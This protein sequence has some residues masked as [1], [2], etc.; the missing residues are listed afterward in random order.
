MWKKLSIKKKLLSMLVAWFIF[1]ILGIVFIDYWWLA[2]IAMFFLIGTIIYAV[3]YIN[4]NSKKAWLGIVI[5]LFLV[6]SIGYGVASQDL[7]FIENEA[8]VYKEFEKSCMN[9]CDSLDLPYY[10]TDFDFVENKVFCS[11][12]DDGMELQEEFYLI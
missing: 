1:L 9:E 12:Y 2:L 10:D 6:Y 7:Y 5:L 3:K 11:C 4:V 8:N